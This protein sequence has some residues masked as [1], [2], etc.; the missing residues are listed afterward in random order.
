MRFRLAY[1]NLTFAYSNGKFCNVNGES[2]N[3]LAF[4]IYKDE[5]YLTYDVD[6]GELLAHVEAADKHQRHDEITGFQEFHERPA[7][8]LSPLLQFHSHFMY[9]GLDVISASKS[10]QR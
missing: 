9:L 1:L 6:S 7:R 3:I 10:S 4:F 8:L 2:H 5:D